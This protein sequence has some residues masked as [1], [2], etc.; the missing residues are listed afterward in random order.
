MAA[1]M[2][3]VLG[4][5]NASLISAQR[6]LRAEMGEREKTERA[7]R[8][9]QEMEAAAQME[10]A[11]QRS[12]RRAPAVGAAAGFR[13]A[14]RPSRQLGGRS[15]DGRVDGIGVLPRQFRAGRRTR[16]SRAR[17]I[18]IPTST[19]RI[20]TASAQ[21]PRQRHSAGNRPGHRIPH[22]VARGESSAGSWCEDRRSMAKTGRGHAHRRRLARHHRAQNGRGA[23]EAVVG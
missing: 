18:L 2:V 8:L 3:V 20:A 14:R 16:C 6:R 12:R 5:G 22:L 13:P 21:S 17:T 11:A 4:V 1:L 19:R 23:P 10:I 9:S 15:G 7:L